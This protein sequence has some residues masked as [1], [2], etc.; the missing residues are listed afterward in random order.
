[1]QHFIEEKTTT[2]SHSEPN[3]WDLFD[4]EKI[5]GHLLTRALWAVFL[6]F[7][8]KTY[9][10]LTVRGHFKKLYRK[11]PKLI[12]ISN[13]TSHLDGPVILSSIPFSY[14]M[15]LYILAAQDY[16]FKNWFLRIFSKHFMKAIPVER[17]KNRT[18]SVK[19]CLTILNSMKRIWMI[20]F[21]EGSR[22]KDGS[23][24]MFKKGVVLLSQKTN[25]PVL[26][27]YIRG[28][29]VLWPRE[30]NF[31]RPGKI[32]LYVGPVHAPS[33]VDTMFNHYKEWTQGID[34]NL[35]KNKNRPRHP[36][37]N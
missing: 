3:L 20:M 9:I 29:R 36:T 14:W 13:H 21:P 2:Q 31:P 10:R 26:F 35:H 1:M 8:F 33:D 11:Y 4:Y 7:V 23:L 19:K 15:D 28:N 27:L 25:T 18:E 30:N 32:H 6:R 24:G 5:S 17:Y 16:W 22:S 37:N 12:I 34:A